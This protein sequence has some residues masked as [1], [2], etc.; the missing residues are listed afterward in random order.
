MIWKML[1]DYLWLEAIL[2]IAAATWASGH[3]ILYKRDVR[4]AVGW[5]GFIWIA[6][7][8]GP[9]A[10]LFF[11]INRI[12]R[13]AGRKRRNRP[14]LSAPPSLLRVEISEGASVLEDLGSLRP[15]EHLVAQVAEQPLLR[16]NHITPLYD[17]DL[18]YQAMW[19]AIEQAKE[20]VTLVSYIFD[21]DRAGAKFVQV[22]KAAKERG[23]EVRVLVDAVG[24][25][26]SWPPIDNVLSDAGIPAASFMRTTLPWKMPFVNLR[27]HRKIMVVD[28]VLGFTGGMNIRE[29]HMPSLAADHPIQDLHFTLYGP[30]VG[31]LQEIF[32]EDWAFTTGEI[33]EGDRWFPKLQPRGEMLA[34]GIADGPDEDFEKLR[35]ALL[36]ALACAKSSVRIMTPYFL[37]DQPLIT[38]LNVAAMRGVQ[39]EILLPE[40]NNL[41]VVQWAST[42]MLWQV[43]QRGCRV[44]AVPPPFDHSK[45][46]VIDESWALLGSA[47]WDPRS[48]RL[49]FEFNVEV[50]DTSLAKDLHEFM[51]KK[52]ETSREISLDD[53]A[54]R[55]MGAQIRDG[56]ARLFSPYL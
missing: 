43:L 32:A 49:N 13:R 53:L 22:L 45:L 5:V 38:S 2:A 47:N 39:V 12:Q 11:G 17:G 50:Y 8:V 35:W 33:L 19:D 3:A 36:G 46:M 1:F 29:G 31:Q 15:L 55:P 41:A 27:N 56:V 44:Y 6:P 52:L 21:N 16:G 14:R 9:L 42:A 25:R 37:P 10:Y 34:R 40:R 18:A 54:R 7:F 24:R 28:G 4:A 26:Y 51:G 23:V 30:I 20:S 48:L